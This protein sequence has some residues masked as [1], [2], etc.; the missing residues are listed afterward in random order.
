M[1]EEIRERGKNTTGRDGK[2]IDARGMRRRRVEA[3]LHNLTNFQH[4]LRY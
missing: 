1:R 4:V 2:K 3:P